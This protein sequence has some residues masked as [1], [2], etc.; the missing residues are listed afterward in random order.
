MFE[1]VYP[2]KKSE[3]LLTFHPPQEDDNAVNLKFYKFIYFKLFFNKSL[4]L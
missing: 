1:V 4:N 3:E 2:F